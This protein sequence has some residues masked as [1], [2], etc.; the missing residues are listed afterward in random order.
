M[1]HIISAGVAAL[2]AASPA[3]AEVKSVDSA[4]FAVRSTATIAAPR[5]KVWAALVKLGSWWDKA[6]TYSGDASRMKLDPVAGGCFCETVPAAKGV[7]EHGRV[8]QVMPDKLLRFTGALGPL[9]S[10]GVA[11]TMTW[12]LKAAGEGTEVVQTYVAGGYIQGGAKA[13]APLVDQVLAHQLVR[14]KAFVEGK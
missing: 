5:A 7:V 1:K 4:G 3:A 14:L 8:I 13:M 6:H 10:E 2:L 11:A 12:E 9:Q